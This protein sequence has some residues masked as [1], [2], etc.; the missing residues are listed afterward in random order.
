M[1][2]KSV[3]QSREFE[4]QGCMPSFVLSML[5]MHYDLYLS[6]ASRA[7]GEGWKRF[8]DAG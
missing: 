2:R 5:K 3:D 4:S 7:E 1:R 8:D 6:V